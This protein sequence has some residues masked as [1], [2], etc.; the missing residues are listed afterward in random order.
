MKT[1]FQCHCEGALWQNN[2]LFFSVIA[3][4]SLAKQ[5]LATREIAALP[6]VARNPAESR[7][8]NDMIAEGA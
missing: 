7:R 6:T 3:S 2:L 5:S 4:R 1:N 8:G